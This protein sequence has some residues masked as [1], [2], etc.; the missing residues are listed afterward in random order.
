MNYNFNGI[1]R[2]FHI[3]QQT[4]ICFG[5]STLLSGVDS[6]RLVAICT[7]SE[8]VR[9]NE[10]LH[11]CCM[12]SIFADHQHKGLHCPHRLFRRAVISGIDF[13]FS[14]CTLVAGDA[15]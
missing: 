4:S 2:V 5:F 6:N 12:V 1:A 13:Q 15:I 9:F 8:F 7:I 10:I 3:Q 14:L 11:P